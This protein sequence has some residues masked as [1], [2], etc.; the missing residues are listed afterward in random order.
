VRHAHSHCSPPSGCSP[1][2]GLNGTSRAPARSAPPGAGARSLA[3]P[4]GAG[5]RRARRSGRVMIP[6]RRAPCK[7]CSVLALHA[8]QHSTCRSRNRVARSLAGHITNRSVTASVYMR[9]VQWP[10]GER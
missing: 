5:T 7:A 2:E 1:T 9:A 3:R 4:A 8:R 6:G 10:S